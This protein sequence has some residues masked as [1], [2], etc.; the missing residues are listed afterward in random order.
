MSDILHFDVRNVRYIQDLH[1]STLKTLY[2]GANGICPHAHVC[3]NKKRMIGKLN[4]HFSPILHKLLT[5]KAIRL[6]D[7]VLVEYIHD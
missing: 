6:Y 1:K 5:L 7:L 3:I 2:V 4:K